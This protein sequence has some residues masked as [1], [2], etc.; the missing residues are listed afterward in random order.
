MR[1]PVFLDHH[2]LLNTILLTHLIFG[3]S[4]IHSDIV[5]PSTWIGSSSSDMN[6]NS[7]WD[8]LVPNNGTAIF[9][10][11]GLHSP[12]SKRSEGI[13]FDQVEFKSATQ[14]S[15][16]TRL[17]INGFPGVSTTPG[18]VA[19]FDI[20]EHQY[21]TFDPAEISI[22][23]GAS[24]SGG[25][26]INYNLQGFGQLYAFSGTLDG[27]VVNV[28]M[29]EGNN[30]FQV[31]G[32]GNALF[33]NVSSDSETD[34]IDLFSGT[35][36]TIKGTESS[37]IF[38][39]ITGEGSITKAGTGILN[40][41]NDNTYTG[42]TQIDEGI[43]VLNGSISGNLLV[44]TQGTLQ[45]TGMVGGSLISSGTVSP[46]NS[47]GTLTVGNFL[48][49]AS[50]VFVCEIN[51]G[52]LSDQIVATGSASLMGAIQVIPLDLSFTAPKTYDILH[53]A[54]GVTGTFSSVTAS[55]PSLMALDYEPNDV[56]LTYLPLST[57]SLHR[58]AAAAA[59]CF[60]TVSGSDA[61]TVSS[62]L[63]ALTIPEMQK[64]FNQM[65]PS[66]FSAQTWTQLQNALLVRSGYLKHLDE[67][68]CNGQSH[69]WIDGIGQWQHQGSKNN[70]FGYRDWTSGV[71]L[72]TD[73]SYK[74]FRF[75]GAVSYTYSDLHWTNSAGNGKI[76]GYYGGLYGNWS[77]EVRYVA[78]T[79]LGS[80]NQYKNSRH[81]H[82]GELNRH[83]QAKH[84]GW[85]ALAGIEAGMYA[86]V[87]RFKIGPF[88]RV[89]YIYLAQNDY[90]ESGAS[91]LNLQVDNRQD[92]LLQSQA[93]AIFTTT[94]ECGSERKSG[95][96]TPRLELSYINQVPLAKSYYHT[97]F[98]DSSCTFNV[99]GWNFLR[100]LGAVGL[101][102]SYLSP[103]EKIGVSFQYDGQLGS[104]YWNQSGNLTLDVKY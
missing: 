33:D 29:T 88:G 49:T 18:T 95:T 64:A 85:E 56:F 66:Q 42:I 38:A 1:A 92:Q 78:L 26:V 6:R 59:H 101:G 55:V 76:N 72:G 13:S 23:S 44:G 74:N 50:N 84:H 34:E 45:G 52:G 11:D 9:D 53:A 36:L 62:E 90:K 77:N 80:Y 97:N 91:S 46:G 15:V 27:T 83:A 25:G 32:S 17:D 71:S 30:Y 10:G 31:N 79:A 47:I 48:P 70:Q 5:D 14:V 41:N 73:T 39:V 19:N 40:L 58:N 68:P 96:I 61:N 20:Y 51:S 69:V 8:N 94:Y 65:Q 60:V 16:I 87:K 22:F 82:F 24:G 28:I 67:T 35:N 98:V 57:I 104:Q 12:I 4:K 89:D 102:L 99:S 3:C 63:I 2:K 43:L 21:P 86:K 100:N 37:T 54:A 93:G 81:L 75:G 103:S 7:N